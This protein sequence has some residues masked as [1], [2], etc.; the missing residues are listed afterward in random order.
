MIVPRYGHSATLLRDGR[1]LIAGGLN[2]CVSGH[3][4]TAT[5]TAELY[6]PSTGK[7]TATGSM[8]MP[9][10]D[11]F[12]VLLPDGT[13]YV[14][15]GSVPVNGALPD[16][17]AS[18]EI[19]D[20]V[21]GTFSPAGTIP[22]LFTTGRP[23][24]VL[25]NNGE[26]LMLASDL[27]AVV[28]PLTGYFGSGG[29]RHTT[30]DRV[31]ALLPN[32][33][34]VAFPSGM[35]SQTF[36]VE[37]WSPL[38]NAFIDSPWTFATATTDGT[39]D[40]TGSTAASA[41]LLP[42]GKILLTMMP[43]PIPPPLAALPADAQTMLYDPSNGSFQ[44][45]GPLIYPRADEYTTTTTLLCDGSLLVTGGYNGSVVQQTEVYNVALGTFTASA[46]LPQPLQEYGTTLL[47]NGDMLLTGGV[48]PVTTGVTAAT[49]VTYATGVD[50]AEIY[51][52][53]TA[54]PAPVLTST[55]AQ[56]QG[57]IWNPATEL[58][59]SSS[60]PAIAGT[61]LSMYTTDLIK[62]GA[63]PPRVA[64]GGRS[65]EVTYFG[66]SPEYPGYFQVNFV[67]PN[68]VTSGAAVP[69]R[70]GYLGRWSNA[71]TIAVQ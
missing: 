71:V 3:G 70:L 19:Y 24:V 40:A 61:V 25:L 18:A 42:N 55:D 46:P 5:A 44:P 1:V 58:I 14:A 49:G 50:S 8:S 32:G 63:V 36:E 27:S 57:A 68:G 22:A 34:V 38:T 65:G 59:A 2:E 30:G 17:S 23:S 43:A 35:G 28:D 37:T 31:T 60:D 54:L 47:N 13:V 66:D 10:V 33:N 45:T 52:P 39:P 26:V 62:D 6:D 41:T 51:H 20:P 69:V 21:S 12:A 64:I 53:A 7:F 16:D 56:G 48:L 67:V 9:R 4:C 29:R 15:A 11:H